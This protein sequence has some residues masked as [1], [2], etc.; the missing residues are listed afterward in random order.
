VLD[1]RG[2]DEGG[3]YGRAG[4]PV[5]ARGDGEPEGGSAHERA[6]DDVGLA[7]LA[8]GEQLARRALTDLEQ[9]PQRCDQGL[10][11]LVLDQ[12]ARDGRS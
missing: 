8:V 10:V 12:E 1:T 6:G 4:Q 5:L 9:P 3:R 7:D 2:Q 11:S